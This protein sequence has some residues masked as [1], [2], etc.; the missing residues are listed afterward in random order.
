MKIIIIGKNKVIAT[1]IILVG[2]L[3]LGT[4]IGATITNNKI[5]KY[6][7]E[8]VEKYCETNCIGCGFYNYNPQEYAIIPRKTGQD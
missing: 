8:N 1:V 6:W 2:I 3:L 4:A 5:Q 7:M